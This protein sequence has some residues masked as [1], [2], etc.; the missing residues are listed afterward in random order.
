MNQLAED[1]RATK[2]VLLEKGRSRERAE[3]E[4][5]SLCPIYAFHDAIG[6]NEAMDDADYDTQENRWKA[7]RDALL[8]Y[9]PEKVG[10]SIAS[11]NVAMTDA[12]MFAA[13]DRAIAKAEEEDVE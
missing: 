13:F 9:V 4:D 5:G 1:L 8:A 7:W 11:M 12:D 10:R 6:L 3:D 2:A